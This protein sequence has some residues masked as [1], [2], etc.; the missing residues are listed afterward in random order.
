MTN[1]KE[2]RLHALMCAIGGYTGAYSL[3]RC[4]ENFGAAQT[5]N[6]IAM[7]KGLLGGDIFQFLLRLLGLACYVAGIETYVFV[8]RRTAFNPQKW[9]LITQVCCLGIVGLMPVSA[10]PFACLYPIFYM[11]AAQWSEFHGACGYNASTIFS[12]NNVRQLALAIG[13]YCCDHDAAQAEKA[14]FFGLTLLSYHAGVCAVLLAYPLVAQRSIWFCL[15]PVLLAARIIFRAPEG[16]RTVRGFSI[17]QR[18]L[19][20]NTGR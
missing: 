2:F 7:L 6:L 17:A 20:K 16:V 5:A 14:R 12:S 13:E 19:L 18:S 8:S 3:L 9:V 11:M 10:G 15:I 4:H 1:Q